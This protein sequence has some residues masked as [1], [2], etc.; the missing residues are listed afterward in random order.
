MAKSVNLMMSDA[1]PKVDTTAGAGM[2]EPKEPGKPLDEE[3]D[4]ANVSRIQGALKNLGMQGRPLRFLSYGAEG[5]VYLVELGNKEKAAAKVMKGERTE[6]FIRTSLNLMLLARKETQVEDLPN[7]EG[8][9]YFVQGKWADDRNRVQFMEFVE[10][11]PISELTEDE[12]SQIGWSLPVQAAHLLL[13]ENQLVIINND[14]KLSNVLVNP[15]D[16]GGKIKIIDLGEYYDASKPDKIPPGGLENSEKAEMTLVLESLSVVLVD[17]PQSAEKVRELKVLTEGKGY[18]KL[19]KHRKYDVGQI[20]RSEDFLRISP[21]IRYIILRELQL[22]NDSQLIHEHSVDGSYTRMMYV[23]AAAL[24]NGQN[25]NRLPEKFRHLF[26]EETMQ[27]L[28]K[29]MR[30]EVGE[31]PLVEFP[32]IPSLSSKEKKYARLLRTSDFSKTKLDGKLFSMAL[33]PETP[34][35]ALMSV[36][37]GIYPD[38]S[39]FRQALQDRSTD[40]NLKKTLRE[41][42]A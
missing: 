3:R 8:D 15:G 35:Q 7:P 36:Y 30:D 19:S 33:L 29:K 6:E 25:P 38:D 2:R 17:H 13:I 10:G 26:T 22:F 21:E 32:D 31:T 9:S 14:P 23:L 41:E 40:F 5:D 39:K 20:I 18:Q 12:K 11:K 1:T 24:A 28:A 27:K 16:G 4:G 42:I 34:F 37:A